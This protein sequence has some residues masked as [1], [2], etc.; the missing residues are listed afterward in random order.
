MQ[1]L[2]LWLLLKGLAFDANALSQIATTGISANDLQC[3]PPL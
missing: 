3:H 1:K 2:K